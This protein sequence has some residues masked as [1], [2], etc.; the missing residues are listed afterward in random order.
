MKNAAIGVLAVLVAALGFATA[1][2]WMATSSLQ[3][4]NDLLRKQIE[5]LTAVRAEA[6]K[7][8]VVK[9]EES[10][11]EAGA[12]AEVIRLRARATCSRSFSGFAAMV[13]SS[14]IGSIVADF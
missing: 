10:N 7:E 13:A 4:Q 6:V 8:K 14:K 9:R 1:R 2:S 5:E 12:E 11:A 3:A